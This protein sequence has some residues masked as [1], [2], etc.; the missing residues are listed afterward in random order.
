MTGIYHHNLTVFRPTNKPNANTGIMENTFDEVTQSKCHL[1]VK[2]VSTSEDTPITRQL[3][4]FK[5]F[6]P[7]VDIQ[8]GDKLIVNTGYEVYTFKAQRPFA[9]KLLK[10]LEVVVEEWQE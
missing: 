6:A 9:Y 2:N 10:K 8:T 3:Q 5:V 1:S 7:I 4:E